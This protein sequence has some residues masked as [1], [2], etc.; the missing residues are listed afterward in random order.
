VFFFIRYPLF[1]S[2]TVPSALES[3]QV[4]L[5]ALARFW[6]PALVRYLRIE[7]GGSPSLLRCTGVLGAMFSVVKSDETIRLKPTRVRLSANYGTNL[8]TVSAVCAPK[9]ASDVG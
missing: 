3:P 5:K 8:G 6:W 7:L 4:L 2:W 9:A 1:L